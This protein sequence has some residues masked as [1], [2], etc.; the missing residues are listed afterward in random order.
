MVELACKDAVFHFNKKHLEDPTIP[1]W[2]IKT[3]GKS[4]YINHLT[5]TVPWSTKETPGN[6]STKGSIKFKNCK[7]IINDENDAE[8]S[9]LSTE[10]KDRLKKANGPYAR[11]LISS[12]LGGIKNYMDNQSIKYGKIR[13]ISGGCG[14]L[15]YMCD[16]FTKED[17]V[18]LSLIYHNNYRILQPN[19]EYYKWYDEKNKEEQE[20]SLWDKIT[21]Q[22]F[23]T[24]DGYVGND[25]EVITDADTDDW[26]NDNDDE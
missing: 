24:S 18:L 2:T 21:G 12:N 15:F 23:R 10:D 25:D 4:Y 9:P 8:L 26:E 13:K 5:S 6:E 11:I 17:A 16:I 1:M 7:L 19:E 22:V 3:G 14:T 20:S